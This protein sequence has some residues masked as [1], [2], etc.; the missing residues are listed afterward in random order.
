MLF[1]SSHVSVSDVRERIFRK[2]KFYETEDTISN[3]KLLLELLIESIFR[4][5][6]LPNLFSLF[7]VCSLIGV[8][9]KFNNFLD[10]FKNDNFSTTRRVV[11]LPA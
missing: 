11:S 6:Y 7:V 2:F 10:L 9:S 8:L 5:A 4:E 1:L 3:S